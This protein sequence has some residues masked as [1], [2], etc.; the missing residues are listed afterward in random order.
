M[1][2]PDLIITPFASDALP[3]YV[4]SIPETLPPG[5]DPQDA[6]WDKG[7]PPVTMTPLAAGG[8]PP[9][10]QSFN[11]VLKAIS[12]HT[13]FLGHGGQYKWSAEYVAASGGYSIGD[14]V[15][16]D[17]GLSSYVSLVN[18]NTANF[19]TTPASIGVSW[20]IYSRGAQATQ[21]EAEAGTDNTKLMT[22]LRTRQQRDK[23][24]FAIDTGTAN[25]YVCAFTPAITTRIEG[26]VLKFKVANA[27]TG[28][29][30]IND[31]VGVVAL[32]GGAQSALQGG[33]L[34]AGGD[35][36]VQW[37]TSVGGGSYILLFCTGASEQIAAGTKSQHAMQVGQATGRLINISSFA[38]SGTFTPNANTK[39]LLVR[40]IGGGGSGGF[41]LAT[42]AGQTSTGTGGDAGAYGEIWV[43]SG[44]GSTPFVVGSGGVGAAGG[45]SSFGAL[46]VC[47]GGAAGINGG[48]FAPPGQNVRTGALLQP[49]GSGVFVARGAGSGGL[50]GISLSTSFAQ[51]GNGASTQLGA[52]GQ[53]AI[54]GVGGAGIGHGSGGGGAV[55][56]PS[57]GSQAGGNGAPGILIV[58]EYS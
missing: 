54:N 15:Q 41:S 8:I 39:M 23:A 58:V 1:A 29:S 32:V 5:A 47:P 33:E 37:N 36:W 11:G 35:A 45:L 2:Q 30:T 9:K 38:S 7:F 28:A 3:G 34:I 20:A 48:A 14:V 53:G 55:C 57:T 49:S 24:G 22:P 6:S 13:V 16:A 27:N 51:A 21:A 43:T 52:G 19:N 42:A 44:I 46:L 50:N 25:T 56:L 26:Q 31:G 18:T 40:A 17:D 12:E 4:D 10:G